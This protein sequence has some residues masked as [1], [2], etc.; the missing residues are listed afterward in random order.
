MRSCLAIIAV[1][2]SSWPVSAGAQPAL[3]PSAR[4]C[5]SAAGV[6]HQRKDGVATKVDPRAALPP[7][8]AAQREAGEASPILRFA[9]GRGL[10]SSTDPQEM[11]AG[12]TLVERAAETGLP[13]AEYRL[14]E[15]YQQGFF[16]QRDR[17]AEFNECRARD[18]RHGLEALKLYARA[19]PKYGPAASALG[20]AYYYGANDARRDLGKAF[21]YLTQ[22]A[23]AGVPAAMRLLGPM[24]INGQGAPLDK[25]KGLE[26]VGL[27]AQMGDR[28]SQ[29]MMGDYALR[30]EGI[31]QNR[32]LAI[33]WYQKARSNGSSIAA[34]KLKALGVREWSVGEIALAITVSG[35][36]LMTLTP[37]GPEGRARAEKI[38]RGPDCEYPWMVF[39]AHSCIHMNSQVV[40]SR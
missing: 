36:F 18:R 27:A 29:E 33:A 37:D 13:Q 9:V 8:R 22:A 32:S 17:C 30:G 35:I 14:G 38:L 34:D 20:Y 39:D 28:Q 16:K 21:E 40:V 15:L 19:A 23:D 10:M 7:C 6:I 26:L 25:A 11:Q 31:Q 12:A 5:I 3:S 2:G 4:Q 24:Y 1:L